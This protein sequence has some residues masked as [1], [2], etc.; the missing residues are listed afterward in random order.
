MGN[1]E[2][3]AYAYVVPYVYSIQS[4]SLDWLFRKPKG[5]SKGCGGEASEAP[6]AD[7]DL[8]APPQSIW[9]LSRSKVA[10]FVPHTRVR[11]SQTLRKPPVHSAPE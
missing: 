3:P 9:A 1:S 4:M 5:W 6:P 10:E 8:P 7:A 2:F 11:Q